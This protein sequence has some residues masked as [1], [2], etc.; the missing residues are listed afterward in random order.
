MTEAAFA[1]GATSL[2][3]SN[4]FFIVGGEFHDSVR[5]ANTKFIETA[6]RLLEHFTPRESFPIPETWRITF[7]ALTDTGILGADVAITDLVNDRHAL[8]PLF[9]AGQEV[10]EQLK[11]LAKAKE[12]EELLQVISAYDSAIAANPGEAQLYCERGDAYA[13]LQ[14]FD[15]AVADYDKAI[16]LKPNDPALIIGRGYFYASMGDLTSALADFDGAI[17]LDPKNAMAYSNRGAAYSKTGNVPQAIADYGLAIEHEPRYANAY[18]NRAYA[19]YKL[20]MYE[21]GIADCDKAL[22]LRPDHANTY[23]NR[24]HCR[25]ALGDDHGA[26]ADFQMALRVADCSREAIEEALSGLQAI[27]RNTVR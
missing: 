18:A 16:S 15:K 9:H 5:Q 26:S 12:T 3:I 25:A 17:A 6:N 8:S 14:K 22:A 13:E 20:G 24:G 2:Y 10:L 27:A 23:N 4:A 19:Y 11:V 21:K 7:Y 1:G